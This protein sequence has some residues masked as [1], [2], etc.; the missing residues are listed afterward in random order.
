MKQR[1]N[2][3]RD[4]HVAAG[5]GIRLIDAPPWAAAQ[6]AAEVGGTEDGTS[7]AFL[8]I[9]FVDR[10]E[11]GP[12]RVLGQTGDAFAFDGDR[13]YLVSSSGALARVDP[14]RPESTEIELERGAARIPLLV[15]LLGMRLLTRGWVLLH[16]AAF[17]VSG[18]VVV[19]TGWQSGGKSELLLAFLA[20]GGTYLADEW[21]AVAAD[22]RIEGL[23]SHLHIWEWQLRQLPEFAARVPRA[24]RRRL[25]FLR[26][27]RS[28]ARGAARVAG[29]GSIGRSLVQ[30]EAW[31]RN[32]GRVTLPAGRLVGSNIGRGPRPATDVVLVSVA[33]EPTR[34]ALT[35][36][37][38]LAAR[39][40]ASLEFERSGLIRAAAQARYAFPARR[41]EV[42]DGAP[43]REREL[44]TAAFS[45]VRMHEI[46]HP[47]PPRLDELRQAVS[48]ALARPVG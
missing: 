26:A 44:L 6:I 25:A 7:D 18:R 19:A 24:D 33:H 48:G 28:A 42:L 39:M 36:P 21:A 13:F 43:T 45:H 8:S 15:P 12:L 20:A 4:L 27:T 34:I 17:E 46:V 10:L 30:L 1:P 35:D 23:P 5:Q 11:H 29:N 3:H 38:E 14:W 47:Y 2:E 9:R 16:A 40:A 37:A 22:G 41:S 31:L 32:A